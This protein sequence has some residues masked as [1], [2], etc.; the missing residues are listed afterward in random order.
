M[1][2]GVV[3]CVLMSA[4]QLADVAQKQPQHTQLLG[5][6]L[7]GEMGEHSGYW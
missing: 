1:T 5:N 4:S 3:C 2:S 6:Q 7:L